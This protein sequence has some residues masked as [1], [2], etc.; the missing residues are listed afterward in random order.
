MVSMYILRCGS[1]IIVS[2]LEIRPLGRLPTWE[3]LAY[4]D[5]MDWPDRSE[6]PDR[7]GQG[8][9]PL[10]IEVKRVAGSGG[11]HQFNQC[12]RGRRIFVPV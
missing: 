5:G 2:I 8:R 3:K 4:K 11:F 10:D 9:A 1:R 7:K 12:C 6:G